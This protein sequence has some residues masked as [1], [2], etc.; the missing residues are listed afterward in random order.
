MPLLARL[1]DLRERLGIE[2]SVDDTLLTRLLN[3]FGEHAEKLCNRKFAR[4]ASAVVYFDATATELLVDR[5]PIE[6]LTTWALREAGSETWT[7]QTDIATTRDDA[8]GVITFV[9][10]PL[11]TSRDNARLTFAGGYVLPGGTVGS[12][13]TALPK[14]IEHAAVEQC[15]HWYRQRDRL[16]LS[17]VSGD[18][19]VSL[20]PSLHLL[21]S[22]E[23]ILKPYR[24]LVL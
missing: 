19:S 10:G 21:A 6:S 23:E 1:T 4:S 17:G 16:G 2:D 12:G 13:Q 5:F 8:S 22:V 15:A 24:R 7:T 14:D 9:D 20:P 3:A 11:G 18:G